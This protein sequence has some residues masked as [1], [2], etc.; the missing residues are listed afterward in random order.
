MRTVFL[1]NRPTLLLFLI[2][3]ILGSPC[4]MW[5]IYM[6]IA[7]DASAAGPPTTISGTPAGVGGLNTLVNSHPTTVCGASCVITGGTRPGGGANLF[8]SFG[9]FN[10]GAGD[11]TT[12]QNGISFNSN[13]TALPAGL[14]TSNILARITGT[15]GNN[16]TLSSI[17]GTLQTSGFGTANLFLMNPAGFLFGPNATVN[18]GGM[19]SFTSADYLRFGDGKLFNALP[20][21]NADALLSSVP[22]AAYGFLGS[23]PGAI[24]VQGSQLSVT[25]GQ[26]ISLVG[27]NITVQSG[28]LDNGTVQTAQLSALGGQINLASVASP[29]EILAGSLA[30]APNINGQSFGNLGAVQITDQSGIDVSGN[31]GGTVIIRGSRFLLDNSTISANVTG[32]GPVINGAESIGNGIDVQ[33]SGDAAIQNLGVLETSV[34]NANPGVTYGGV[35]VKADRIEIHGTESLNDFMAGTGDFSAFTGIRSDVL[36]ES[37]G[38]NSGNITLEANSIVITHFGQLEALNGQSS[39]SDTG[40]AGG[41]GNPGNIKVTANQELTLEEVG[42]IGT[43]VSRG[44]GNAGNIELTSANGNIAI[45]TG[46]IVA[47]QAL[48]SSGNTGSITLSANHGDILLA[49]SVSVGSVIDGD[50]A[51]GGIQITANNLHLN[52]GAIGPASISFNN[53]SNSQ[54]LPGDIT[55]TLSGNL[56]L[57]GLSSIFT[58]AFSDTPA[59]NLNIT[60][61][62]VSIASGSFLTTGS[63]N[64]GSGGALN[65]SA[66]TVQMT[67]GGQIRSASTVFPQFDF[68]TFTFVPVFPSGPGGTINIQGHSGPAASVLI[69]GAGSGIFT[70]SHGSGLG[71]T[72]NILAQS[73]TIQ[74]GGAISAEANGSGQGGLV[75]ISADNLQ[76]TNGGHITSGSLNGVLEEFPFAGQPLPPP[77]GAAGQITLQGGSVLIDG[78]G[79][80]ILTNSQGTGPGGN[81]N[82]LAQSLTIQ[83]GATLSAATTGLAPSATGGTITVNAEHVA[84]NNQSVITTDTNGVAPAGVVDINTGTLA[85][86]SGS[87]IRSSSGAETA[88]FRALAFSPVATQPLAGGTITVQGRTGTG[89]Q[90]D[91]VTIDGA[92]SGVFTE[93]TGN[94]PGG[95]INLLTSQSVALTN[96]ASISAS[97]TGTGNAGN[98]QINAGNQLTMNN[99]SVTTE[100][101]QASG[102]AI[103]ITTTPAGSVQL[104]DSTITAS[105]LDGTG[106]G[107]SV[108]ID[109]QFVILQNSQILAQAVQGPGGNISITTNLLLPDSTSLISASSQF[110]QQG[111]IVIQSPVSPASGKL[112]PLGQKPLIATALVS[113]RCAALAGGNAS[114][115]TVAGRDSLPAE[116]SGW[117]SSPLAL[118]MAEANEGPATETAHSN[119]SEMAGG[120]PLLPLRKIA[121]SGFLTQSFAVSSSDGCAS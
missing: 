9:Q 35:H 16:P 15:N 120:S 85:I 88:P 63:Q 52:G 77:T 1:F 65:I 114:S 61:H 47:S 69:D 14:P 106:G 46:A 73:V 42:Q 56:S 116:P 68:D 25:A 104:T 100:A 102:G 23:N 97:S 39:F 20:N 2:I 50:G 54:N 37:T 94:R 43:G 40:L 110:G 66:D 27:G 17:Y 117:V 29:G 96:G 31:G 48:Q 26:S 13:G 8:H 22:V 62:D 98:I 80:G 105:V 89:S 55:I 19:V 75:N 58:N 5:L 18:V 82:I 90:A 101:T 78:A 6:P 30:Q 11:I 41:V 91:S 84:V 32:P 72:T 92:G 74:N 34:S 109:P 70:N 4:L 64:V 12:F 115:F 51:L 60:A 93:S 99:S 71:G 33:V 113:Q 53:F 118:S 76:L 79:S 28:A 95:D 119:F 59:A 36:P 24:T 108:D 38:G 45:T 121:P 83:N 67:T 103:K 10:I 7:G 86:N 112:V 87:Q 49:E 3:H 21:P 107:G 44:T 81:A 111:T 57:N